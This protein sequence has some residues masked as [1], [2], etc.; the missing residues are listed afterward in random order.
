MASNSAP[1]AVS[2]TERVVRVNRSTPSERSN[3]RTVRLT[4]GW[5]T[6]SSSAARVNDDARATARNTSR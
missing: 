6:W 1:S 3:S 5:L 4:T 2:A